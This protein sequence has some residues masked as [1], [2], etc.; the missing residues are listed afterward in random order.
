M[1]MSEKKP[2]LTAHDDRLKKAYAKGQSISQNVEARLVGYAPMILMLIN[3]GIALGT[4]SFAAWAMPEVPYAFL[5]ISS[6]AVAGAIAAMYMP[7]RLSFLFQIR[8]MKKMVKASDL[9]DEFIIKTVKRM[10]NSQVKYF[11]VVLLCIGVAGAVHWTL[12]AT[13]IDALSNTLLTD[14]IGATDSSEALI[15]LVIGTT[16]IS[17]FMDVLIGFTTVLQADVKEFYPDLN[18]EMDIIKRAEQYE[19]FK[20]DIGEFYQKLKEYEEDRKKAI[21]ARKV[22]NKTKKPPVNPKAT[23]KGG[24]TTS[25]GKNMDPKNVPK[26]KLEDIS[27][28]QSAVSIVAKV[29]DIDANDLSSAI[30]K[31]P[32]ATFNNKISGPM[33]GFTKKL[34]NLYKQGNN[35]NTWDTQG[36]RIWKEVCREKQKLKSLFKK[37]NYDL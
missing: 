3:I 36:E 33:A 37:I 21:E 15:S 20:D 13:L 29:F 4:A 16:G 35:Q 34:K 1:V 2:K 22:R 5:K 17:I 23:P 8:T 9:D 31:A 18:S 27:G 32:E 24:K 6:I 28:I 10:F 12:T 30:D 14:K 26:D 25:T 7:S 11:M 19:V